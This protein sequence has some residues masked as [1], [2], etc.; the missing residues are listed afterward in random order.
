MKHLWKRKI[1][2]KTRFLLET[3]VFFFQDLAV[4][5][6]L[7]EGY[8][9]QFDE[10]IHGLEY[11]RYQIIL[12]QSNLQF[13]Q[14]RA[15]ASAA[16]EIVICKCACERLLTRYIKVLSHRAKANKDVIDAHNRSDSY[17]FLIYYYLHGPFYRND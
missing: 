5:H 8:A 16:A 3:N 9:E 12:Y 6:E 15:L 4:I 11:V 7:D 2:N 17:L 10:I 1:P 14:T 13:F